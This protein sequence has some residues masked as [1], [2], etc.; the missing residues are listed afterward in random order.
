MCSGHPATAG[1]SVGLRQNET[2]V[3]EKG[4]VVILDCSD[5]DDDEGVDRNADGVAGP[6]RAGGSAVSRF[7]FAAH[8]FKGH[9]GDAVLTVLIRHGAN[10]TFLLHHLVVAVPQPSQPRFVPGQLAVAYQRVV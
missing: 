2:G 10:G 7:P 1:P 8:F 4:L 6:G 5:D 3:K 9:F